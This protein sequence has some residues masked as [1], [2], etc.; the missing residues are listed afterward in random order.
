MGYSKEIYQ[1]AEQ[2]LSR[3][4]ADAQAEAEMRR[5]D[6]FTRCPRA[7]EIE[8]QLSAT[9]IHAA[10]IVLKQGGDVQSAL[11]NLRESNRSLQQE[12]NMLLQKEHMTPEDLQPKYTCPLCDDTGYRDGKVCDC[13]RQQLRTEACR[14]LNATTP[15]A[16][17]TFETFDLDYYSDTPGENGKTPRKHMELVYTFCKRYAEGF[18]LN[19]PSLLFL[20]GTGLSKT[21]LSLAIANVVLQKGFGVVYDSVHNLMTALEKE[22]FS[23]EPAEDDTNRTLL[24]C[25]LLI[26]DDLGTEFRTQFTTAAIYNL[27]NTRLMAGRPTIISTNL[28]TEEMEQYYTRRFVSRVS[29]SYTRL[30]FY[31]RDIRQLKAQERHKHSE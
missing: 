22:R 25:D 4:R 16:L 28:S 19:S 23:R 21:H 5:F 31:G 15:L 10:K 14:K 29:S 13:L 27:V 9:A 18:S 8:R 3:R 11:K 7:E 17:S 20:G 1:A 12:L 24:S 30:P 6:F 26:L 2:V